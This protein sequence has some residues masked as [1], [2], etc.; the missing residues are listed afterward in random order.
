MAGLDTEFA[1]QQERT[2]ARK[3]AAESY[4]KRQDTVYLEQGSSLELPAGESEDSSLSDSLA[5][6]AAEPYGEGNSDSDTDFQASLYYVSTAQGTKRRIVTPLLSSTLD[7]A[8]GPDRK[9][10]GVVAATITSMGGNINDYRLSRTTLRTHRAADRAAIAA[11][12]TA[13]LQGDGYLSLFGD[14]KLVSDFQSKDKV[15]RLAVL[16]AGIDGKGEEQLLGIPKV[17]GGDAKS[18]S[19]AVYGVVLEWNLKQR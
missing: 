9:A 1:A 16:V 3:L 4:K 10:V 17:N 19:E 6:N 2:I 18:E 5:G 7:W 14:G 13:S 12:L 11:E 15:N 8:K